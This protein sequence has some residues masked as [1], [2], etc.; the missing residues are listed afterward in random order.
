MTALDNWN[1]VSLGISGKQCRPCTQELFHLRV[2]GLVYVF[3]FCYYL[4]EGPS[5]LPHCWK[6]GFPPAEKASRQWGVSGFPSDFI[7]DLWSQVNEV[8]EVI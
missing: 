3:K 6:G 1:S 5:G 7:L 4:K 2:R 8:F